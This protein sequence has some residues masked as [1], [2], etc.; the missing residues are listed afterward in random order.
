MTNRSKLRQSKGAAWLIKA[1]IPENGIME[2]PLVAAKNVDKVG[3]W[4]KISKNF[5]YLLFGAE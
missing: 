2:I 1:E 5:K 4:G 3:L